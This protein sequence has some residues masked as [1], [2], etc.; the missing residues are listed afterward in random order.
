MT[1]STIAELI[2]KCRKHHYSVNKQSDVCLDV[3]CIFIY[4]SSVKEKVTHGGVVSK[5]KKKNILG[6]GSTNSEFRS[7]IFHP[8]TFKHVKCSQSCRTIYD[9]SDVQ[10]VTFHESF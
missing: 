5:S 4:R 8:W 6:G 2:Y 3:T 7:V 10:I 1:Q 9:D